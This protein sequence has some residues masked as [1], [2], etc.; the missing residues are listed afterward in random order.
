[1]ALSGFFWLQ[2]A[3]YLPVLRVL[4]TAAIDHVLE[5]LGLEIILGLLAAASAAA[6]RDHRHGL[7]AAGRVDPLLRDQGHVEG[8][9]LAVERSI[10][11]SRARRGSD[12]CLGA[13]G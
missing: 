2:A 3:K 7:L 6:V 8:V 12:R 11:G 1:M 10:D 4:G 13:G 5:A 9:G